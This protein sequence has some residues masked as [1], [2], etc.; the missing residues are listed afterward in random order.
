MYVIFSAH[1]KI[2]EAS[3]FYF[4]FNFI[5]YKYKISAHHDLHGRPF[6]LARTSEDGERSLKQVHSHKLKPPID[7]INPLMRVYLGFWKDS[8]L[9]VFT[10]K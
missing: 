5:F 8:S 9:T 1:F 10:F 6:R 2:N 4:I 7:F 3:I